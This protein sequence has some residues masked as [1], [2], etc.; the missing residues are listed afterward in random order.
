MRD[1]GAPSTRA[2]EC[3]G[4]SMSTRVSAYSR[5][6][7]RRARSMDPQRP[8]FVYRTGGL[9]VRSVALASRH[10]ASRCNRPLHRAVFGRE[11]TRCN[12]LCCVCRS[13]AGLSKPNRRTS[14]TGIRL[15]WAAQGCHWPRPRSDALC[16]RPRGLAP[17]P[18]QPAHSAAHGSLVRPMAA[19]CGPWQPFAARWQCAVLRVLR[20]TRQAAPIRRTRAHACKRTHAGTRSTH[21]RAWIH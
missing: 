19:F 18:M 7:A 9:A 16:N 10:V 12:V 4:Y 2:R 8:C 15:P 14:S 13:C 5:A 20:R 6:A 1:V 3:V 17:S 11:M 21:A